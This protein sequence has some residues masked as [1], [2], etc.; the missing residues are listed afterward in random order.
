[1]ADIDTYIQ[2]INTY[3]P[4]LMIESCS[5]NQD[6]QYNDVIIVNQELVFR[7]A[8]VHPAIKTL[9]K[10]IAILT[11]IRDSISVK[12]PNPKYSHVNTNALGEA[13]MG[14]PMIPGIPL[15]RPT[16]KEIDD[17]GIRH[18]LAAQLSKFLLEL[19]G[20]QIK[21][22]PLKLDNDDS[23]LKWV[24]MYQRIQQSLFPYMRSGARRDVRDHFK[25]FIDNSAVH[26]FSPCLRHGDFGTG[27]IL[28]DPEHEFIAG[29]VDFGSSGVGDPA[30]DFASLYISFGSDFYRQAA[31][32][33]PQMDS[34]MDR[35]H[36]YCGTF[37][38]QEAL[39]GFENNDQ[40]AFKAGME[41]YI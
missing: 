10:E 2:T 13:F 36:F 14:Y 4:D 7:F 12:V 8:K 17:S 40:A 15:W 20:Y 1:V 33:Y 41:K 21:N 27:N 6:G 39:F 38:L 23:R 35:V 19:H 5:F 18:N 22:I 32:E 25:E 30:T 24:E 34:D 28:Y 26:D 31:E 9:K 37:A 3:Y 11:T 29:V 16:F